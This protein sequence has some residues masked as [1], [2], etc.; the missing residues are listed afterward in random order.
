MWYDPP[1]LEFLKLYWSIQN[2]SRWMLKRRKRYCGT[3]ISWF[4]PTL[5]G[6]I[7]TSKL[8]SHPNLLRKIIAER[9]DQVN[10][11]VC[12]NS[13]VRNTHS[14][15]VL[16]IA[17]EDPRVDPSDMDH[18]ALR[19]ACV[20]RRRVDLTWEI[21]RHPKIKDVLLG[22][23][24]PFRL[25][26]EMGHVEGVTWFLRREEKED[27]FKLD[28]TVASNDAIK[29]A[30]LKGHADIVNILLGHP[31]LYDENAESSLP[32]FPVPWSQELD[33]TLIY[34]STPTTSLSLGLK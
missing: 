27:D 12:R 32:P 30:C 19:L 15:E 8:T 6:N 5:C 20:V 34:A 3:A 11:S 16:K 13:L 4:D 18:Q 25:F 22:A 23:A 24:L 26:C 28:V 9:G 29:K 7:L 21:V 2:S 1:E 31:K 17:L 14:L 33:S 10:L